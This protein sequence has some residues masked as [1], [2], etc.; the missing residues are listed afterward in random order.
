MS[1]ESGWNALHGIK[2]PYVPRTEYSAQGHWKLVK[3]VTGIDTDIHENRERAK[4]EFIKA[5]DYAFMWNILVHRGYLGKGRTV[6][7]GHAVYSE[8][9][10]GKG[11][12]R[13]KGSNVWDDL[14]EAYDL[15]FYKEYGAVDHSVMIRHY[16]EHFRRSCNEWPDTVNMTGI[17]ITLVSGLI[18]IYGWETL[19][20]LLGMDQNR[21][22]ALIDRYAEWIKPFFEALAECESQVVMVH[23]DMV[24]T[25][26]PFFDPGWYRKHIFPHTKK[27]IRLLKDA[28]KTVIFTC[29]GT[30]T[31]FIDDIADWGV[32]SMVMEPTT[33]MEAAAKRHGD[34]VGF[35]GG[36]DTR[37]L[38]SGTRE[39]IFGAVKKAMDI[40]KKYPGFILAVG[41]HIPSNTPVENALIY[42]E[43]YLKYRDR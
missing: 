9:E 36:V 26:G 12:Y 41:N 7:M 40:G 16:N 22:A 1:F 24:W 21:F 3:E 8:N 31:E 27:H 38:L 11:D 5:W 37:V 15:D 32:D 20:L 4:R 39:E 10:D 43:A 2:H 34:R 35:V 33:D 29:D 30:F 18:E 42:Q 28:G 6:D 19:L 23:D 17:Y 14:D 13:E 25:Q